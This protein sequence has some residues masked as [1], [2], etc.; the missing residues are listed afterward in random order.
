MHI[1][2]TGRQ[3]SSFQVIGLSFLALIA[4]GTLLLMLPFATQSGEGAPFLTALFT[5]VSASC[6]TGLTVENTAL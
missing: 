1:P 3:F 4:V 5:T 6:V 2:F